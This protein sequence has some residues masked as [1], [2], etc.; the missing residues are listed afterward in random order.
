MSGNE[1]ASDSPEGRR[2]ANARSLSLGRLTG[3]LLHEINNPLNAILMNA[4]LGAM[5]AAQNASP[6]D[7]EKAFRTI[8]QEARRAGAL[9]RRIAEFSRGL[10]FTPMQEAGLDAP[11]GEALK[12]AGS[13]L[14]QHN[15]RVDTENVR[16]GPPQLLNPMALA[17]GMAGALVNAVDAGADRIGIRTVYR[18]DASQVLIEDNGI[19]FDAPDDD[20]LF[21]PYDGNGAL[22]G[23]RGNFGL[24]MLKAVLDDHSAGIEIGAGA[25]SRTRMTITLPI[26]PPR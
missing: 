10:R 2:R 21:E 6:G 20:G 24:E 14:R 17:Q 25:D 22:E 3:G 11:V 15:V 12:L 23:R 4:E 7:I 9:T 18:N 16:P 5:L 26:T 1:I 13:L 8:A 19:P